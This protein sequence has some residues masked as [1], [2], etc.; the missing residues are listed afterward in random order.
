MNYCDF[1]LML[2]RGFKEVS[3]FPKRFLGILTRG[4]KEVLQFSKMFWGS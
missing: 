1:V 4:F 2:A 3:K